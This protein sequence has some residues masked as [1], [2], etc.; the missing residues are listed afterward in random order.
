MKKIPTLFERD[1]EGDRSRV[2]DKVHPG[3]EWVIAGDGVATRKLDGTCCLVREARLFKRREVKKGA[4]PPPNFE[5]VELDSET[6]NVVGWVPVTDDPSDRWHREAFAMLGDGEPAHVPNGTYELI[7]P[8]IQGNPEGLGTHTLIPHGT[9]FAANAGGFYPDPPRTFNGLRD[10]LAGKDIE[11]L[12][13]HHL[14]GRM[15]KIK[16]RDFGLKRRK[17]G[18]PANLP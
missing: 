3:C 16:L 18:D 4:T 14:D 10:W 13:F 2:V 9:V 8:K 12:V 7:G 6:G 5:E 11:G 1:W 15:A 17:D